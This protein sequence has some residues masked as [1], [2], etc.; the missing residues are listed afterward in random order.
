MLFLNS[1]TCSE[2]KNQI[3]KFKCKRKLVRC[4]EISI[5]RPHPKL[6]PFSRFLDFLQSTFGGGIDIINELSTV[7]LRVLSCWNRRSVCSEVVKKLYLEQ[8]LCSRETAEILR[9][10]KSAVLKNLKR[11]GITRRAT[12]HRKKSLS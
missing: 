9:V 3:R 6:S 2:V 7:T 5:D 12:G 8:G 4:F 11:Q 10:S 1:V